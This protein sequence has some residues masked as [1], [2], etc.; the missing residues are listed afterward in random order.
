MKAFAKR[1]LPL[2]FVLGATAAWAADL[3]AEGER[4][5]MENKPRD[6]AALLEQAVKAPG[7]D[8]KA[9]LYLGIAY[10][11]IGRL[12]DAVAVLRKGVAVAVRYRHLFYYNMGNCY[13][14]QGKNSFA[15]ETYGQSIVERADYAPSYLNRANVRLKLGRVRDA[16][17]DYRAYLALE[18]ASPQAE[19]IRR[20]LALLDGD[21]AAEEQSAAEAEAR[22]VAE[23]AAKQAVLDAL[24]QSLKESSGD[25]TNMTGGT[26]GTQGY[27]EG[28]ELED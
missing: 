6:A 5:F 16:A 22:R 17:G 23:E 11:Q 28:L 21:I 8:E 3:F 27:G 2:L 19:T 7:A 25:T 20:L 14:A 9:W 26:D 18:P 24:S 15:E 10:Q 13:A 12:D 1:L 4:L